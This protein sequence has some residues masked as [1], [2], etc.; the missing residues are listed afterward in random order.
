MTGEVW[1]ISGSD[2]YRWMLKDRTTVGLLQTNLR[3]R[4]TIINK[5]TGNRHDEF[6]FHKI[7]VAEVDSVL[8]ETSVGYVSEDDENGQGKV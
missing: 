1:R 2:F 3:E 6:K 8:D 7:E 5:T 4:F